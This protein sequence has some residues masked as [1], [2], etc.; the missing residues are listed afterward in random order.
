MGDVIVSRR[1]PRVEATFPVRVREISG[2]S[3]VG[4]AANLSPF[5]VKIRNAYVAPPAIVHL[6]FTLPGHDPAF[7]IHA[8]AVRSDTDGTAFTFVNL[9]KPDFLRLRQ[10]VER[11]FLRR[12]LYIMVVGDD[13]DVAE[14][15]ANYAEE[16]GYAAV[17]MSNAE[18]A[19]AY[20]AQDQPDAIL[21]DLYLAGMGG[22]Q[23]LQRLAQQ[24]LR[25]PVVVISAASEPEAVSSLKAGV[26]HFLQ[27]PIDLEQFRLTLTMLELTST[28]ARLDTIERAFQL[29]F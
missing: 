20:M 27:K 29:A 2:Q 1:F 12:Q 8:V 5:G 24:G 15:L 21:L 17:I 4:E 10:Q 7:G 26:L 13:R 28:K 6:E 18:E 9:S 14:T 16:F 25:L 23:F 19:L 22:L 3:V 11:L